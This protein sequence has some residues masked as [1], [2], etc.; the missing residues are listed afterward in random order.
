MI[1]IPGFFSSFPSFLV[2]HSFLPVLSLGGLI[3]AKSKQHQCA[4][5][6]AHG[7]WRESA[8]QQKKKRPT[9]G[10][11][12]FQL[13]METKRERSS[14]KVQEDQ[15]RGR[16]RQNKQLVSNLHDVY[17]I[18][19]FISAYICKKYI[20]SLCPFSLLI[21]S[22]GPVPHISFLIYNR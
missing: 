1:F 13:S 19:P 10:R 22:N 20:V 9:Q 6:G 12:S 3:G 16:K 11:R 14:F 8:Q 15:Q 18:G 5:T 17:T 7:S 4:F 2:L 21:Y